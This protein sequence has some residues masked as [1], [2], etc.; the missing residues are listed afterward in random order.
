MQVENRPTLAGWVAALVGVVSLGAALAAGQLVAGFVGTDASPYLAVGDAVVDRTPG[1][2]KDFAVSNFG[3]NDKTVL[4]S[5]MGVVLF[6]LGVVAGLVSRRNS[7]PGVVFAVV[8]GVIGVVAVLGR[9]DLGQLGV[10]AP[11]ASLVVGAVAFRMLHRVA[12]EWA[13]TEELETASEDGHPL[14]GDSAGDSRRK[15][16]VGTAGVAVGAGLAGIVGEVL[17]SDHNVEGSRD[18]VGRLVATN[19]VDIPVGADFARQGTPTFI[20]GNGAF[21]RVDTALTVPQVRTQDWSLRIHGMVDHEKTFTYA[22]IRNRPLIDQVVTLCCVSNPV[23]GPYISTATFTGV[24]M[25]DLLA[26][27]GVR[28]GADQLLSTSVDGYTAGTPVD[29]LTDGRGAMLAIGMN[30]QPL[31]VEHGFPARMVVP[32]LYGYVSA[33]KWVT[34]MELTTFS[35]R[36]GYWVPRG[37]SALAPVK[38]E[39]RIDVPQSSATVNAGSV[40]VAGIAWAQTKGIARVE[41]RVDGGPWQDAQLSTEVSKNTWRM[42]RIFLTLRSGQHTVE[43]RATDDTGYTQTNDQADVIPD[44]ATGWPSVTFNVR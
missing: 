28:S 22:D 25:K 12:L 26:E 23:G 39:S 27:V 37:Y 35:A 29:T 14:Y 6:L 44:G 1:W 33:T 17:T 8:L 41:V 4:L 43:S 31:P 36:Q 19:K 18:A 2:L 20:T 38:T 7:V 34:D 5:V 13:T 30:G 24:L 9:S 10:L 3:T 11:V 21:Y 32:G 15:F 40:V 42:W 16:L